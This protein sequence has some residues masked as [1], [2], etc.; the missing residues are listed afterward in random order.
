MYVPFHAVIRKVVKN[1]NFVR[2]FA[3]DSDE[4]A[5]TLSLELYNWDFYINDLRKNYV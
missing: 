5:D 4:I 3:C 1:M 2:S